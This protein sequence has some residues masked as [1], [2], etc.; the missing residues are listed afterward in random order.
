MISFQVRDD[1]TASTQAWSELEVGR[2]GHGD[3]RASSS[4]QS[5]TSK[6]KEGLII[7][8]RGLLGGPDGKWKKA[9]KIGG[10]LPRVKA[11]AAA[12]AKLEDLGWEQ[13]KS[14]FLIPEGTFD[15]VSSYASESEVIHVKSLLI[16]I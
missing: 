14:G 1:R 5:R 9:K 6:D 10:V 4:S 7:Y 3:Q 16:Y 11:L 2:V 15:C 8:L 12:M 13:P